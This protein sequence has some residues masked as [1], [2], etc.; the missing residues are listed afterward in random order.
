[1][2]TVIRTT[3]GKCPRWMRSIVRADDGNHYCVDTTRTF[4]Y[5]PETMVFP[6]DIKQDCVTDWKEL[7][8]R[9]YS[10]MTIAGL[11]HMDIS[12]NVEECMA[13]YKKD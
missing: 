2:S 4:D 6:Y 9:R 13:A 3:E 10:D 7:Y 11:G 5:G 1:M 8:T 12:K